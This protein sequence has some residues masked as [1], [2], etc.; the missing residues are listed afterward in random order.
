MVARSNH[1]VI[2][3]TVNYRLNIF[4]FLGSKELQETSSDGSTGNFGIQDQ[5][6]AM[7][8]TKEH[9]GAFGGDGNDITI[10]GESAGGNSVMNHLAHKNSFP[11]YTKAIVESGAYSTGAGSMK[12]AQ[13]KYDKLLDDLGCK[14]LKCLLGK[15][16]KDVEAKG[17]GGWGPTVESVFQD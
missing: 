4:G 14:N 12:D 10:F 13:S 5:R 17:S 8:W 11:F 15:K 3:V 1:S 16:A 7:A 2:C 9:I 6:M